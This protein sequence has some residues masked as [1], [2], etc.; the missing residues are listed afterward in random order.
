MKECIGVTKERVA[1]GRG[2]G[3]KQRLGMVIWS[4]GGGG[5]RW[6]GILA[7]GKRQVAVVHLLKKSFP[8][9]LP[10]SSLMV[11]E[12]IK[13]V[14]PLNLSVQREMGC[15]S[16]H[17]SRIR[18][19]QPFP[20]SG[21]RRNSRKKNSSD[22]TF[23]PTA[24]HILARQ[25]TD[26]TFSCATTVFASMAVLPILYSPWRWLPLQSTVAGDR[27]MAAALSPVAAVARLGI[28]GATVDDGILAAIVSSPLL[29]CF[30]RLSEMASICSGGGERRQGRCP[31]PLASL[32]LFTLQIGEKPAAEEMACVGGGVGQQLS[33]TLSPSAFLSISRFSP[34]NSS[35]ASISPK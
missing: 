26:G 17:L 13:H 25:H 12:P 32:S 27:L 3:I 11:L 34:F 33:A 2:D 7:S 10:I 24:A 6:L 16:P 22:D 21:L 5:R 15:Y 35:A 4:H 14:L 8:K 20:V 31:P 1:L 19:P 30:Y 29:D 28:G 18:I 23:L 9:L